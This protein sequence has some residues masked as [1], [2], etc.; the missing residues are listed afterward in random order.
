MGLYDLSDRL[1][2]Q[3]AVRFLGCSKTTFYQMI[4]DGRLKSYGAGTRCR[5]VLKS[6]CERLLVKGTCV[7]GAGG[8]SL[9]PLKEDG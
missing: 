1:N 4:R 3:Q 8:G 2:W 6:D 7:E 5:F 9:Q